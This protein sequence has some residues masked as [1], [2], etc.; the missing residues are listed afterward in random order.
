MQLLEILQVESLETEPQA[1]DEV[2]ESTESEGGKSLLSLSAA[3]ATGLAVEGIWLMDALA[4]EATP[5]SF[6]VR[7]STGFHQH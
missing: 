4:D 3:V 6:R 1:A 2:D 5:I 7:N